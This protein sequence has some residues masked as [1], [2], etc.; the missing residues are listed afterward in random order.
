[1]ADVD[2]SADADADAADADAD[3]DADAGVEAA[4]K[5]GASKASRAA[6]KVR[7]PAPSRPALPHFAPPLPLPLPLPHLAPPCPVSP[8]PALAPALAPAP[9]AAPPLRSSS[10]RPCDPQRVSAENRKSAQQRRREARAHKNELARQEE[11][12]EKRKLAEIDKCAEFCDRVLRAAFCALAQP[13][14]GPSP[15]AL[16]TFLFECLQSWGT[17]RCTGP[18]RCSAR[19]R[20]RS[21]SAKRR[22]A[23][24][25]S[26]RPSARQRASRASGRTRT[27][28]R[29]RT[30]SPPTS[31]QRRCAWPRYGPAAWVRCGGTGTTAPG[32][33][34]RVH[35]LR[36][37]TARGKPVPRPAGQPAGACDAGATQADCV[38][39]PLWPPRAS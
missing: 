18:D 31:C 16:L 13:G 7:R 10:V 21:A 35:N 14:P 38:R 19:S 5:T 11:R 34:G 2:V 27:C 4:A 1:M 20:P 22:R 15:R 6:G 12:L 8:C 9:A 37:H 29:S 23:F 25:R 32:S 33:H 28:R 26:A 17:S 39:F 36:P 30:S 24:A 3:S